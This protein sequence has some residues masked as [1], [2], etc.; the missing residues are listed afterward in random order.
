[1]EAYRVSLSQFEGPLDLLLHLIEKSE[2]NIED[3]FVSEITSQ[4]LALLDSLDE[5]DMDRA[6]EFL[7]VAAQLLLIKSRQLLPRPLPPVAE[8]EEDPE[9]VFL[10]RLKAYKLF[11][12][13]SL[14]LD[15]LRREAAESRTR[16]PEDVPLPPQKIELTE[17]SADALYTAFLTV[18]N[19]CGKESAPTTRSVRADAFTVRGQARR[20]RERLRTAKVLRFDELFEAGASRMELVVTFM[21]LLELSAGGEIRLSQQAAFA[22]I[23]IRP[24]ALVTD[25]TDRSYQDE[26]EA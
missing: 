4:Y 1:M 10:E 9:A 18:L 11:K 2:L 16:L 7:T 5:L 12:E 8:G 22:P 24:V 3:V 21:A 17:V 15:E 19:R 25:D 13:Q 14:R 6:S 20:I 26:E 23:R